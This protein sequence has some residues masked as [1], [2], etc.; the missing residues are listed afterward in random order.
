MDRGDARKGR[1]VDSSDARG[2]VLNRGDVVEGGGWIKMMW[3]WVDGGDMRGRW[4]DVG[5]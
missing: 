1:W 2:W 3:K 5:M 4:V